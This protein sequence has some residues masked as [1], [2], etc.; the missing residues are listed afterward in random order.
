MATGTAVSGASIA[1]GNIGSVALG[2][3]GGALFSVLGYLSYQAQ[4][5]SNLTSNGFLTQASQVESNITSANI[6]LTDNILLT[7]IYV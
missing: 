5:A 7:V 2:V 4:V 6:L 3:A 1:S